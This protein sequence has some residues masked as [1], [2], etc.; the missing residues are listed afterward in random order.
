MSFC[1]SLHLFIFRNSVSFFCVAAFESFLR[2][3]PLTVVMPD[4]ILC[5][6]WQ[7]AKWVKVG[8]R[9]VIT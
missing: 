1:F 6:V 7:R 2:F 9:I 3:V 4:L 5:Y 8:H